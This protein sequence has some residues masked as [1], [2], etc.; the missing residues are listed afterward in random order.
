MGTRH[1]DPY[2]G[3]GRLGGTL[4]HLEKTAKP[5]AAAL[6][7]MLCVPVVQQPEAAGAASPPAG[8]A[9]PGQPSPRLRCLERTT[10]QASS[11]SSGSCSSSSTV[12]SRDSSEG[13]EC[14]PMETCP[15][16]NQ[17]HS[18]RKRLHVSSSALGERPGAQGTNGGRV[19]SPS[20]FS[21]SGAGP[22]ATLPQREPLQSAWSAPG[23]LPSGFPAF[24]EQPPPPPPRTGAPAA[25]P[26][27]SP[28]EERH[29][30]GDLPPRSLFQGPTPPCWGAHPSSHGDSRAPAVPSAHAASGSGTG[31]AP[32]AT[33]RGERAHHAPRDRLVRLPYHSTP[34]HRCP[35]FTAR[36]LPTRCDSVPA[37]C[38]FAAGPALPRGPP[39]AFPASGCPPS[40]PPPPPVPTHFKWAPGIS[41]TPQHHAEG[42][43]SGSCSSH[44]QA[45]GEVR[46]GGQSRRAPA[47]TGREAACLLDALLRLYH[48]GMVGAFRCASFQQQTA[49]QAQQHVE[50]LK[51]QLQVRTP[52]PDTLGF[53]DWSKGVI[54]R[55]CGY[56]WL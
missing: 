22:L 3:A 56:V 26:L 45:A 52:L 27:G 18:T 24:P 39:E 53:G 5:H 50:E 41:G 19:P 4:S 54:R 44:Q 9:T 37:P 46:G 33:F 55:P 12:S 35:Y 32:D 48:L 51:H 29:R 14:T 42:G 1:L 7:T 10:I 11:A 49:T 15:T 20:A 38:S 13:S 6:S 25:E 8:P 21:W 34:T 40:A 28:Y 47:L 23:A 36:V 2:S 30:R 16:A 17:Q 31:A 43:P